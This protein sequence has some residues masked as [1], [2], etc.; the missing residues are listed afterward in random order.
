MK[1]RFLIFCGLSFFLSSCTLY[2]A[3][4]VPNLPIPQDFKQT[5][6]VTNPNLKEH[7]WK[8]FRDN[9]L[10]QLVAL[11]VQNNYDYQIAIKNIG[12][13][14]TYVTQNEASLFP[15]VNL[16]YSSSRN[17]SS[18]NTFNANQ[19]INTLKNVTS[20]QTTFNLNQLFFSASYQID[21][22]NQIGNTV[23]QA[24]ANVGMTAAQGNVIKLSL[25]SSVV[26]T[27]F[28][29]AALN[30][31]LANLEQQYP[32]AQEIL[33]LTNTQF[34]SGLIDYTSVDDAKNQVETIKSDIN[35][36]VKQQEILINT[37]AY[38]VGEYPENANFKITNQL[39]DPGFTK[40]IPASIPSKMLC[41][42]PDIQ[43]AYFN[44]LAYGYL[45]KQNIANFFPQ[46]SL[47]G[48]YGYSSSSLSNFINGNSL[49]W[50]FAG[51]MIQPIL[52]FGLRKSEFDRS[53]LQ[54][55]SA[56]LS[57]K[58]TVINAFKEVD[59][60][61]SSYQQ[62]YEALHAYQKQVWNL[63]DKLS[64]NKAQYQSGLSDYLTYLNTKLSFLQSSYNLTNQQ[65]A[66]TLDIT[67]V[68]QALGLGLNE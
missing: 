67:Q 66:V 10:N 43:A 34:Q 16:N 4:Q 65:L 12:I 19:N 18:G 54:Y 39:K 53:K 5:I 33:L 26:N 1:K 7:W 27:Y 35:S 31:T 28:Q 13:A 24:K 55:Q 36:L 2:Q 42:R 50:N 21:V 30:N 49:L 3:P 25:I 38:L 11:V 51:N 9:K 45:E 63:K 60:A 44:V 29:I 37:L 17:K 40:L 56:V 52:D 46:F 23:N 57:Y 15:Q 59:N 6:K 48:T 61:L 14:K 68:Y 32:T 47:T 8:N 22:W 62:D 58:E 41:N 64:L 20:T